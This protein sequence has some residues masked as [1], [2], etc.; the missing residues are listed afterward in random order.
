MSQLPPISNRA[1]KRLAKPP[2]HAY[3]PPP[4]PF[5]D[6]ELYPDGVINLSIAENSLLSE[7]LLEH[8]ARP[9]T[10]LRTQHLRYRATLLKTE[11]PTVEDLIPQYINDHFRP[12]VPVT[13][14]NCVTGPGIGAVLA[15]LVWAVV[16]EGEGVLMSAPFY[17]DYV[18]DITHPA[19]ATLVLA[20]LPPT[21]D[22][23]SVDILPAL[24]A[25]LL[26]SKRAGVPIKLLLVPNPHNPLP[27]IVSRAVIEG[28]ALLAEKYNIHLVVDEVY[29]LSTFHS[30]LYPPGGNH[31]MSSGTLGS[32]APFESALSI[33]FRALGVDPARVHVLAGPT[34]DFGASGLKLGLIVSPSNPALL[35]LLRP[36]FF[37]TPISSVSD[38]LF[39][40]VLQDT[41]FVE[42]FLADNRRALCE[43]Y[44]FAAGWC[45]WHGLRFTR[46]NAAVYV[47]VDFAPFL[48]RLG[49]TD[50]DP[51]A[52]LDAAVAALIRE[53]VFIKPT[54]LMSDPVKTRFRLIFTQPRPVMELA[55]RRIERAFGAAEAPL[56]VRAEVNGHGIKSIN[57]NGIKLVNGNGIKL[58]NGHGNG[59]K[60]SNGGHPVNWNGIKLANGHGNGIKL[61]GNGHYSGIQ[62]EMNEC[63][64]V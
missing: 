33:D 32:D 14:D 58:A 3:Y 29:A 43:A 51:L 25:K 45:V 53:G 23:L 61:N 48:A 8:F 41:P 39:A 35:N 5:Y 22:P 31:D 42:R 2:P 27:R 34:K 4:R 17:D 56:P 26:E 49:V 28:Y 36:L 30:T 11:L 9:L 46:A 62:T 7:R 64:D 18:R 54:N 15:Q 63:S 24:E 55:L 37:A 12:R 16:G 10:T 44:E 6:P 1:L 50:P 38:A 40:R 59:I 57:G 47:V 20:S 19:L 13:R 60:L 52:V 21:A